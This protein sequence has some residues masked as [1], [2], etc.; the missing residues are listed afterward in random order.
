MCVCVCVQE[1]QKP[2]KEMGAGVHQLEEGNYHDVAS[3]RE[4]YYNE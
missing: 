3:V 2:L 1:L 4:R